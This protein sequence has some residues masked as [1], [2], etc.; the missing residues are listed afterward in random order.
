[1]YNH[2]YYATLDQAIDV[3]KRQQHGRAPLNCGGHGSKSHSFLF[4]LF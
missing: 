1:M 4:F 3:Y 2:D